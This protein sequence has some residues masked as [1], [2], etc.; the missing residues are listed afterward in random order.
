[1]TVSEVIAAADSSGENGAPCFGS[2]Y[3]LAVDLSDSGDSSYGD[4]T[5]LT[6]GVIS[7]TPDFTPVT[8]K[9]RYVDG[10]CTVVRKYT[11]RRFDVKLLRVVDDDVQNTLIIKGAEENNLD[12]SAIRYIYFN[13][14][15]GEGEYGVVTVYLGEI[16]PDGK[17]GIT[18]TVILEKYRGEIKQ[19]TASG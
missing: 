8:V 5:V 13:C 18:F 11:Q 12:A 9:R 19:I 2:D 4:F 16:K 3:L 14:L 15:T 17:S 10:G 1:M 6:E 7:I